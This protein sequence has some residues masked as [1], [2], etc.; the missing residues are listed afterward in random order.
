M[1]L[2]EHS[3][4]PSRQAQRAMRFECLRILAFI[5]DPVNIQQHTRVHVCLQ[6]HSNLRF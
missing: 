3:I 1:L 6:G 5:A 2:Q 4:V